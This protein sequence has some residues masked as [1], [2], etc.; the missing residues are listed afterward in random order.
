MLHKV[1][2]DILFLKFFLFVD[3]VK[4]H[5]ALTLRGDVRLGHATLK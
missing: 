1:L 2:S 5:I 4:S 3:R